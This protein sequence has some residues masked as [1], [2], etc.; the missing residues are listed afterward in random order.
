M[1]ARNLSAPKHGRKRLRCWT[2][3]IALPALACSLS[4]ADAITVQVRNSAAPP[5]TLAAAEQEA[6]RLF[7]QA[8]VTIR[9]TEW[10][11][12]S[13]GRFG[14][15]TG[16][17]ALFCIHIEREEARNPA[18]RHV[19]GYA[20]PLSGHRNHGAVMA[21]ELGHSLS[22]SAHHDEGIMNASWNAS[23]CRAIKMQQLRFTDR[24]V[25]ALREGLRTR[26]A[27]S[28]NSGD[29]VKDSC[30]HRNRETNESEIDGDTQRMMEHH[31][32][33]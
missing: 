31:Q 13:G 3:W 26:I 2:A 19:L 22:G 15:E 23:N 12:G 1:P 28:T 33:Q 14:E 27:A 25:I 9:W 30:A 29:R 16:D 11:R 5:M 6:A 4:A 17:P 7:K 18:L 8:S 32:A 10:T 21:H 20:M 24:E